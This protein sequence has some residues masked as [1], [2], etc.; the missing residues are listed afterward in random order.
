MGDALLLL[1]LHRANEPR[2]D[3]TA[4]EDGDDSKAHE[5]GGPPLYNRALV[6]LRLGI[7]F[8]DR[9]LDLQR[10][11]GFRSILC[12]GIIIVGNGIKA[13]GLAVAF[14]LTFRHGEHA[15]KNFHLPITCFAGRDVSQKYRGGGEKA[16]ARYGD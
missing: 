10:E 2:Y 12:V 1:H 9:L 7:D 4:Y 3:D 11:R 15:D 16:C 5:H 6:F 14:G 8:D 13:V